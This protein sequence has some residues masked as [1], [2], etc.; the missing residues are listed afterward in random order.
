M[1]EKLTECFR[2]TIEFL[3]TQNAKLRSEVESLSEAL[4][5]TKLKPPAVDQPPLIERALEYD[6]FDPERLLSHTLDGV[7]TRKTQGDVVSYMRMLLESFGGDLDDED[8]K[9]DEDFN[10]N[11]G[12]QVQA[13][14][15]TSAQII[16]FVECLI[17]SM[18]EHDEAHIVELRDAE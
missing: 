2:H 4:A 3:S 17:G 13:M 7:R 5:K 14:D 8:E 11:H 6:F 9:E 1:S 16:D 18:Y 15:M 10:W 12:F